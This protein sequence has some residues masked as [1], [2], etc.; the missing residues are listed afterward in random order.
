[1]DCVLGLSGGVDSAVAAHLL[2]EK[3]HR[4]T[5][6]YL[7]GGLGEASDAQKA[8]DRL[9]IDFVRVDIRQALDAL[10]IAPFVREYLSARTPNPCVLCNPAVKFAALARAADEI[11]A[12]KIA[13]GHYAR[14]QTDRDTGETLLYASPAK[15]DQSYM[16]YRLPQ[17]ILSRCVF[18]LG[19]FS[20]KEEV[21]ALAAA[22]SLP[23]AAKPDSMEICFIPSGDYAAFIEARAGDCPP[24]GDFVT[25][26]GRVLGRHGGIHRYTVG[27]RR[28]LGI[29]SDGRLFVSAIDPSANRVILSRQDP[30][31][32]EITLSQV[33]YTRARDGSA[34][35]DAAIKIRHSRTFWRGTVTPLPGGR[36][37]VRFDPPARAPS[38]GQSAVFYDG[39]RVVGGGLID[40][41]AAPPAVGASDE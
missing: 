13:T 6:V 8:A 37:A 38:P 4:V 5:G 2:K 41:F 28:G 29:S 14:V 1:M 10:V 39:N 9:G 15:N 25:P 34:P 19:A 18:P 16:L 7:D 22:L 17:P 35:F 30:Y 31:R 23:S 32:R 20:G 3:G 24:P 11:G 26:E 40:D 12:P 36:A 33:M 27:Q 21:R